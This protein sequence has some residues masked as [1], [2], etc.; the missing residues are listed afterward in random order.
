MD[1]EL[2]KLV[3]EIQA[4]LTGSDAGA[5]RIYLAKLHPSD[6][7]EVIEEL[8][9]AAGAQVL[10]MLDHASAAEALDDLPGKAQGDLLAELSAPQVGAILEQMADDDLADLVAELAPDQAEQ[11]LG[12]LD[13]ED[14]A[15]VKQLMAYPADTAGG[16]MT[17]DYA[18]VK[19]S[20]TAA[21]AI[22]HI[23]ALAPEAET[24]NYIYVLGEGEELCGVLS[25]REL[26][27]AEP[28]ARV[29]AIMETDLVTVG[30][31]DDQEEVARAAM[32][33]DLLALPV[34]GGGGRLL[35][36]VT[37]DDLIDVIDAEAAEDF[38]GVAHGG[39]APEVEVGQPLGVWARV[40]LRLPWLI[41]LMFGNFLAANVISGF[42]HV[43]QSLVAL[44]FFIPVLMDMG[45]NVGTQSLAMTIRGMTTGE[46]DRSDVWRLMWRELRVGM[47]LG[48]FCGLLLAGVVTV[49]QGWGSLG[50]VVGVAMAATMSIASVLGTLVP[51]IMDR[52]GFDSAVASSPFITSAVDVSGLLIYFAV[53]RVVLA[54]AM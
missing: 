36:I 25:L 28:A 19:A 2:Q 33:Y 32:H 42:D 23:R 12:L 34:I 38:Y 41:I 8:P 37:I 40:R 27:V 3:T 1:R 52:L 13:R 39:R 7:A 16:I 45:G 26:I 30:V 6:L 48:L 53:A 46:I 47:S 44:A 9:A 51:L 18:W 4:L 43:L 17:T 50:V 14:A 5:L 24:A 31:A 10:G 54:A 29:Q 21:A 22:E 20:F 49:W 15:D 35:G 11:V